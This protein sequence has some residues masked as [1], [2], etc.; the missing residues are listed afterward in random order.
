[1]AATPAI[2]IPLPHAVDDHQ[3]KNAQYLVS[4]GGAILV[5]Q[6]DLTS[7]GLTKLLGELFSEPQILKN[8]AQSAFAAADIN[9]TDKVASLCQKL[10]A[11]N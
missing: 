4:R 8:M 9:A 3:V 1:M 6:N 10:A 7:D 2:F 5:K 11:K